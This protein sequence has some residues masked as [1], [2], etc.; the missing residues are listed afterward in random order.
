MPQ[1]EEMGIPV[2]EACTPVQA[3]PPWSV[4][5]LTSLST[6]QYLRGM[7]IMHIQSLT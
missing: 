4:E 3:P 2:K 1:E 6:F 5:Q 7:G